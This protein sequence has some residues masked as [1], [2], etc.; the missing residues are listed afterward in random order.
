MTG[1]SNAHYNAVQLVLDKRYSQ[2]LQFQASY[3]YSHATGETGANQ[4]VNDHHIYWGEFGY[5][6]RSWFKLYGGYDLPFG[7]GR[8]FGANMNSFTNAIFGGFT[9]NAT[10]DLASG[11][12]YT[13][14]FSNGCWS[15]VAFGDPT[16]VCFPNKAGKLSAKAGGLNTAGHYVS[17]FSPVTFKGNGDTEGPWQF[18]APYTW[19]NNGANNLF[20]PGMFTTDASLRKTFSLYEEL[21]LAVEADVRNVFNHVNLQNPNSCIDCSNGGQITDIIGGSNSS[22]GGMRQFEFG[23]HLTF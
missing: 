12:P 1:S 9:L 5:N 17:Y 22:L 11:L 21:K 14:G 8:Q 7:R 20:G 6:R 16:G 15:N 19:G 4:F 13:A 10:M 23:A 2:G 3:S 18:P